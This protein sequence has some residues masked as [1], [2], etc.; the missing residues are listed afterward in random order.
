[1]HLDP[2]ASRQSGRI[3]HALAWCTTSVRQLQ[4]MAAAEQAMLVKHYCCTLQQV[5]VFWLAAA[6]PA[7]YTAADFS[8]KIM[9]QAR[10]RVLCGPSGIYGYELQTH[11]G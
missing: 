3:L 6:A 5:Y 7:C 10:Q 8:L 2:A 11:L 1:M 9:Q 4:A